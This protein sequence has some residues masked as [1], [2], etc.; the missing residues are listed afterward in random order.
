MP[1]GGVVCAEPSVKIPGEN[2]SANSIVKSLQVLN[3]R[4]LTGDIGF[5]MTA[6]CD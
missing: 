4:L 5:V 1:I 6:A 2:T 3:I